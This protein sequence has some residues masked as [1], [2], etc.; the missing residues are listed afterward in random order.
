MSYI[1]RFTPACALADTHEIIW[2]WTTLLP[3]ANGLVNWVCNNGF[4][5]QSV[6]WVKP[7]DT[8]GIAF[9]KS[10]VMGCLPTGCRFFSRPF[11]KR[12]AVGSGLARGHL[13]H[14]HASVEPMIICSLSQDNMNNC[15]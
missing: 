14:T 9:R 15:I 2:P 4:R 13:Q 11:F 10:D 12:S 5:C 1:S 6:A 3:N 7:V 8:H